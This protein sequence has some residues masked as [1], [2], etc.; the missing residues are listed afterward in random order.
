M[1]GYSTAN[2]PALI[3]QR[4]GGGGQIWDYRSVDAASVV[5]S[6]NYITN[7]GDLGIL[8]SSTVFVTDTDASP[9]V[10]GIHQ[11]SA[12]ANGTTDL[13]DTL[14]LTVTDTD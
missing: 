11:V 2:P 6:A 3:A 5:D 10:M 7:G 12:V 13:N 8:I 1:A 14:A 9:P 4:I